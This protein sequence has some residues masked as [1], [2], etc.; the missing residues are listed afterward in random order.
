MVKR[1]ELEDD[2]EESALP[3][4]V[5]AGAYYIVKSGKPILI[6]T[7]DGYAYKVESSKVQ[8]DDL[9]PEEREALIKYRIDIE[10]KNSAEDSRGNQDTLGE[11]FREDPWDGEGE[12]EGQPSL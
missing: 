12:E 6:L 1:P 7:K 11:D 4:Y 2:A 10:R 9:S 5:Y 8:L 3:W